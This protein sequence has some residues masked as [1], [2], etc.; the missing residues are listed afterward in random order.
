M[1]SQELTEYER[2][3]LENIKRN[4]ELLASLK[5]HSKLADLSASSKR[6]REQARCYRISLQKKKAKPETPVVIRKSLRAQGI[7]PDFSETPKEKTSP[8][9]IMPLKSP[10]ELTPLSM[11]DVSISS[12]SDEPLV[13]KILSVSRPKGATMGV[14]CRVRASID[15]DS[16]ELMPENIARVVPGSILS[17]KFFPSADMRMV[18][19]G[20]KFG[21]LGFWNVDSENED[22]DGIHMYRPH[23]ASLSSI[24]IHPFAMNKIITCCYHGLIRTLDIQNETF[25]LTYHSEDGIISMSQRSDDIN[26]LYFG[27][28]YGLLRVWDERSRTSS[29]AWKLHGSKINT[30][31]FN[32]ENS[33][34]MATSSTDGTACIW[35]LRKLGK[36][37]NP[38]SLKEITRDRHV[39]SAYF[40]PSGR[41]L[42]TT[43]LDDKIGVVSGANYD[44]EFLVYHNNQTGKDRSSFKG[45]WGW[46]DSYV[47]IGNMN[48]GVDV[49]SIEKKRIIT[50]LESPHL[51]AI[52]C[53]FDA[54]PFKAGM[55]AGTTGGRVCIW[56][57]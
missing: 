21:D 11:R 18:A 31:D 6:R 22:G 30:I 49:V 16:M 41:L 17:V 56:S 51:R 10:R 57:L 33:N 42:A 1:A 43:S 9:K 28:G 2:K 36:R 29:M 54:H 46:D 52:P 7:K 5:I 24:C 53:R 38:D 3:R 48:W 19:V 37:S 47:F 44:E 40:S 27:E 25:D 26:S 39:H 8:K 4:D 45:V 20:S 13:Q 32:P 35:D 55:L 50:T 14:E 12:K 34:I 23:P 15:L